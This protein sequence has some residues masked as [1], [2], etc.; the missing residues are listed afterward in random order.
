MLVITLVPICLR[1]ITFVSDSFDLLFLSLIFK[2]IFFLSL[3]DRTFANFPWH[4]CAG[5]VGIGPDFDWLLGFDLA[6]ADLELVLYSVAREKVWRSR[7]VAWWGKK[8]LHCTRLVLLALLDLSNHLSGSQAIW[9]GWLTIAAIYFPSGS[10]NWDRCH[11]IIVII[12]VGDHLEEQFRI[13]PQKSHALTPPSVFFVIEGPKA[14]Q[15]RFVCHLFNW[16]SLAQIFLSC[17]NFV[18]IILARNVISE[19][20]LWVFQIVDD[21]VVVDLAR[22]TLQLLVSQLFEL[23][24]DTVDSILVDESLSETKAF[25]EDKVDVHIVEDVLF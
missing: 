11:N 21:F 18:W 12:W 13:V 1:N 4:E 16:F 25:V 3:G 20:T 19:E 6:L 7:C 23:V 9:L 2:C 10:S 14:D 24:H 8:A 15:R 5:F 17:V 22:P